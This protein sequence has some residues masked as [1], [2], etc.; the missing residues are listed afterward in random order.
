MVR[1]GEKRGAIWPGPDQGCSPHAFPSPRRSVRKNP[2]CSGHWR[3]KGQETAGAI[4]ASQ[5]ERGSFR[6]RMGCARRAS[7]SSQ[8]ATRGARSVH[9][10]R[11]SMSFV[12]RAGSVAL[13]RVAPRPAAVNLVVPTEPARASSRMKSALKSANVMGVASPQHH[14]G[15]HEMTA[16]LEN[17]ACGGAVTRDA[18]LHRLGRHYSGRHCTG[19]HRSL[20][21]RLASSARASSGADSW[22]MLLATALLATMLP[23][24]GPSSGKRTRAGER[25]IERLVYDG[26][27]LAASALERGVLRSAS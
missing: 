27:P 23:A 13:E 8:R 26:P 2:D 7:R 19:R 9:C 3:A 15:A 10:H 17:H 5:A 6:R 24:P 11:G 25:G 20:R 18:H 12:S 1:L 21:C 16:P 22:A 4:T 14:L